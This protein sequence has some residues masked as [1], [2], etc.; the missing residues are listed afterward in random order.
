M[1]EVTQANEYHGA[2]H[3][4]AFEVRLQLTMALEDTQVRACQC[5]FCTRR[6]SIGV[7]D[8]NGRVD[9]TVNRQGALNRYRFGHGTADFIVCASCGTFVAA[10]M[11]EG[12][13]ML[14]VINPRGLGIA[15]LSERPATPID[16]DAEAAEGRLARRQKNWTPTVMHADLG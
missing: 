4:G 7:S 2:C 9:I 12:D 1:P 5:D 15:A 3:C 10:T 14:S 13:D 11:G 16:F 8:P 6:G